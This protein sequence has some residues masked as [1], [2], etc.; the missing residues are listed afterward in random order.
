[1]FK[2]IG[3]IVI[4][5]FFLSHN[6]IAESSKAYEVAIEGGAVRVTSDSKPII[7]GTVNT[8]E[9]TTMKVVLNG[10]T[11]TVTSSEGKF[12]WQPVQHLNDGLYTL[13]VSV[14]NLNGITVTTEQ[15]LWVISKSYNLQLNQKGTS[16]SKG[17]IGVLSWLTDAPNGL[18]IIA[19][20]A[21]VSGHVLGSGMTQSGKW[22]VVLSQPLL[23]GK[24][25]IELQLKIGDELIASTIRYLTVNIKTVAVS[26]DNKS[27][28][29]T[30]PFD[31]LSGS[32]NV[33]GTIGLVL[34][35]NGKKTLVSAKAKKW[36]FLPITPI[37]DGRHE[38]C[39]SVNEGIH[40]DLNGQKCTFFETR[41]TKVNHIKYMN[42]YAD[43]NYRPD[44]PVMRSELAHMIVILM[45]RAAFKNTFVMKQ[46]TPKITD[47]P[48]NHPH[49]KSIE[50]VVRMGVMSVNA[51]GKFLPQ[52]LI[53]RV[54]AKSIVVKMMSA[55]KQANRS[56]ES[57]ND[58][59]AYLKDQ[60]LAT[61]PRVFQNKWSSRAEIAV[62]LN[63]L[64]IRGPLFN[65]QKA[66]WRD[67]NTKHWAFADIEE[68]TRTHIS[69]KIEK[70]EW[71]VP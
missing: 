14:S 36:A 13:I 48:V 51:N 22:Q 10:K 32:L 52:K 54:D 5:L 43:G 55:T 12:Q 56:K 37:G 50:R 21:S 58:L 57:V 34:T 16:P 19:R 39:I 15:D 62:V 11:A 33:E 25:G 4:L 31:K 40:K 53:S 9:P 63:R 61:A 67:V 66:T 68:A 71:L 42:G 44:K 24:H 69:V 8:M 35:W 60:K 23:T 41:F 20:K 46:A 1:M 29:F 65:V 59:N 70:G 28:Y 18:T 38:I 27:T 30:T 3:V 64:F 49:R 2:W 26:F 6:V 7:Q 17:Q 47:V 45:D